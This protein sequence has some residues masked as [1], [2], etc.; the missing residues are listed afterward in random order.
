M[1]KLFSCRALSRL[2]ILIKSL[3]RLDVLRGLIAETTNA[4]KTSTPVTTD[5][6]MLKIIQK[7]IKSSREVIVQFEEAKRADLKEKESAQV[8]VLEE[9][10]KDSGIMS[11]ED[12]TIAIQQSIGTMRTEGTKTDKGSVMKHL[13]GPGGALENQLVDKKEVARIVDGML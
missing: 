11:D 1:I 4:A 3:S 7:K 5:S 8:K 13:V 12:L 9:Y 10:M 2:Q 6:H